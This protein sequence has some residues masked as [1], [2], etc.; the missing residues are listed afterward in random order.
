MGRYR[1]GRL[2]VDSLPGI[3]YKVIE[4]W[5]EEV[6]TQQPCKSVEQTTISLELLLPRHSSSYVLLGAKFV[7]NED[8]HVTVTVK[9]SNDEDGLY[10]DT[11]AST[12]RE[13]VHVG[14]P[15]QYARVVLES[16]IQSI[17]ELKSFPPGK[18]TFDVGAHG[19]VGSSQLIFSK[20]AFTIVRLIHQ[21]VTEFPS[22]D[23]NDLVLEE[24]QR[25]GLI[26]S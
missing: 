6:A 21:R 13:A 1:R 7:P 24:L 11:I 14:I 2:W 10:L 19:L 17:S 15:H 20:V 12:I 8:N 22:R 25:T 4:E 26:L 3:N 16:A 18:L 5:T 9:I 23:V